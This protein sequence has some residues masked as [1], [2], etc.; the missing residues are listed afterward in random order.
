M[1]LVVGVDEVGRG[2]IAGPVAVASFFMKDIRA[3]SAYIRKG[4]TLRDSKKLSRQRREEWYTQILEWQKEGKC[5]FSVVMISAKDIDA[6]GIAPAIRKALARS[7]RIALPGPGVTVLLD[8][9]LKAPAE[10][11]QQKTIIKGDEKEKE[12]ALASIVAK[13]TRDRYMVRMSKKYPQYGFER[14]VGYGTKAHYLAIKTHGLTP[15][16]RKSFLQKL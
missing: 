7:L 8:G 13:V 15:L 16:H 6:G 2:P 11:L 1:K 5:N 4:N 14:H 10:Y 12:I 9:G 3:L